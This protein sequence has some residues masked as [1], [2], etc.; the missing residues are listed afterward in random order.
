MTEWQINPGGVKTVLTAVIG[1]ESEVLP[2][3][4]TD[5]VAGALSALAWGGEWTACVGAAV[6]G[7]VTDQQASVDTICQT[8][9]AGVTGVSNATLAYEAGQ[10]DMAASFQSEMMASAE[11]GDFSFFDQ[12]GY[13]GA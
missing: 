4:S 10:T 11:D 7:L 13:Q 3:V 8:I 6:Q 12:Y 2:T 5:N 9:S 1:A